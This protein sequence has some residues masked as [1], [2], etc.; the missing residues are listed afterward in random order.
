MTDDIQ[1]RKNLRDAQAVTLQTLHRKWLVLTVIT[2]EQDLGL[3]YIIL[4]KY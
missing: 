3:Q 1:C 4:S 2:Q